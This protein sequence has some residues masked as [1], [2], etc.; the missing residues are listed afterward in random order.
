MGAFAGPMVRICLPPAESQQ[1][2]G[3][4]GELIPIFGQL[5][6]NELPLGDALEP[7]ALKIVGFDA[8]L[9]SRPLGQEPLDQ[10]L[11]DPDHAAVFACRSSTAGPRSTTWPV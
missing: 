4:C 1:R 10:A 7:G 8:S 6:P 3:S 2:T 9:G 5:A 11:R